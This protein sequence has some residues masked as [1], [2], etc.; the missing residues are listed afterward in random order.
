MIQ[1]EKQER[2]R[3]EHEEQL[4]LEAKQKKREAH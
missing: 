2:K 1:L 3:V 4:R